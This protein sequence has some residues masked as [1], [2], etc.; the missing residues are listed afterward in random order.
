MTL[1]PASSHGG[2]LPSQWTVGPEGELQI[3]P[4]SNGGATIHALALIEPE[5]RWR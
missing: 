4:S 3:A 5:L 2:A 1:V